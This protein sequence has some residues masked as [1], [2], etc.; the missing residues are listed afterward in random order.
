MKGAL[1]GLSILCSFFAW[2]I[3]VWLFLWPQIGAMSER[4]ALMAFMV[5]H[6]FRFIG[7]GFLIP[8]VVSETLPPGFARPAAWGDL[9]AALLA[10]LSTLALATNLPG[11]LDLV[12]AFNI[13]GTIDLLNAMLQGPRKL[14]VSGPGALGATFYIPT[15]VVPGLLISHAIIF[16][17]LTS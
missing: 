15:L 4:S 16:R 8:G 3:V 6:M 11:A 9:A 17:L 7:L 2:G 14:Q 13:W 10:M 5:P 12:W 1:F